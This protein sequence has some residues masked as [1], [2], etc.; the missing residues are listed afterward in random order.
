MHT[1]TEEEKSKLEVL[2]YR[3]KAIEGSESYGF[4]DVARLSLAPGMIIPH[5]FKVPE[6]EKYKGSTCPKN[7]LTMYCRKMAAYAHDEKLLIHLFQDSLAESSLSWYTHLEFS[8]ICSWANLADVFRELVAQVEL[9][10]Y[11]KEM[12]GMFVSTLSSPFHEHMIESVT[13]KFTGIIIINQNS[14]A[15]AEEWQNYIFDH[16]S[17]KVVLSG[18]GEGNGSTCNNSNTHMGRSCVHS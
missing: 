10:L 18:K 8:H 13:S 11:N 12:V 5:K 16:Y 7:Q 3:L 1:G 9:P 4:G 17:K 14:R 15:W 6:F 2:E